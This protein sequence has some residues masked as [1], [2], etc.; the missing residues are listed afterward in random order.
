MNDIGADQDKTAK[1][2][3]SMATHKPA[4]T[5]PFILMNRAHATVRREAFGTLGK[6]VQQ[7]TRTL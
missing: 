5:V 2:I 7:E 6:R 1:P 3:V 4:L